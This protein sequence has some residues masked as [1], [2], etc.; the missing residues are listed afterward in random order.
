M[1][2]MLELEMDDFQIA[3]NDR[4]YFDHSHN[5]IIEDLVRWGVELKTTEKDNRDVWA[6]YVFWS[7]DWSL[8]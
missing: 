6:D 2:H 5:R 1:D 4:A 3:I 8:L 7:G